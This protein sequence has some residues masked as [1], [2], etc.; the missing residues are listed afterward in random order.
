VERLVEEIDESVG[1]GDW[2]PG[3]GENVG[4][5]HLNNP[6]LRNENRGKLFPD[7]ADWE[8]KNA[9]NRKLM[10]LASVSPTSP[11]TSL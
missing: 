8:N 1:G 10:E 5:H 4:N 11:V 2:K 9:E 7:I 3:D 6:S